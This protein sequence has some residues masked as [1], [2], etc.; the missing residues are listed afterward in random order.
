LLEKSITYFT[1]KGEVNTKET[2][3]LA[4][5]R[6]SALKI[7]DIVVATTHGSTGL[8]VAEV[9][10][11]PTF[12]IVAVTHSAAYDLITQE[13][14]TKLTTKGIKVLTATC[15]LDGDVNTAFREVFKGIPINEV[16][17]KTLKIFCQGMKVCIE[18]AL[19][20]ADAGLIP[21]DK[22]VI[23]IAGSHKGADTAVVVKP[24]YPSKFLELK[25]KEIIAK[26]RDE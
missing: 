19:M 4:Y 11:D 25:V 2:I 10:N 22:E 24:A 7:T 15:L 12:N 8:K 18:I 20:A 3:R 17:G 23:A 9:F 21:V 16:V 14:R 26:P 13:E 1:K 6:A 5:Q